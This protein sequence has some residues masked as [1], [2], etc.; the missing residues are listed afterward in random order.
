MSS[1][2]SEEISAHIIHGVKWHPLP[3]FLEA[4]NVFSDYLK[5]CIYYNAV[6]YF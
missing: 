4:W 1:E 3:Y 2:E 5:D 6:I